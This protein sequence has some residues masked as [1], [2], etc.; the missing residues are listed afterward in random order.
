MNNKL[1]EQQK[2][3]EILTK[4]FTSMIRKR[5]GKTVQD[6]I[7]KDPKLQKSVDKANDAID[8]F[9]KRLRD[10]IGD[11]EFKKIERELGY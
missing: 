5:T 6:M 8:S 3:N 7:K 2:I 11:K 4:I 10:R 9:N 1:T